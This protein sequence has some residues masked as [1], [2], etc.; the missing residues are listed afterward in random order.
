LR[1]V[2]STR[3]ICRC[4]R[5]H[6][7]EGEVLSEEITGLFPPEGEEDGGKDSGSLGTAVS[8]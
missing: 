3:E 1:V 8:P 5:S 7:P 4:N 6:C 2:M